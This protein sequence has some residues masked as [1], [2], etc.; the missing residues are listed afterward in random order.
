MR[1]FDHPLFE[2]A[3]SPDKFQFFQNGFV[4]DDLIAAAQR[5]VKVYGVGPFHVLPRME[6]PCT[7]RGSPS[8]VDLQVAIAQAGPVQIELIKDYKNSESIF[9]SAVGEGPCVLHQ[10][11]TVTSDYDGKKAHYEALGYEVACELLGSMRVAYIDTIADFGFFT[12]IVEETPG[13]LA[14]VEG[15]AK[16]CANWDGSDPIRILTR[17]GYRTP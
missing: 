1:S 9:R 3:N 11:C 5:W 10:V 14:G 17:N 4:V 7:Y 13:F 15:M 6:V 8:V 2:Q 16:T 12:E